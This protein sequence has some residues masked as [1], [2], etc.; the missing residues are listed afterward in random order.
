VGK[1]YDVLATWREKG[2]GASGRA[3]DCGRL[4]PEEQP[5]EVLGELRAFFR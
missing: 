3:L 4:L 1:L 5:E 2:I